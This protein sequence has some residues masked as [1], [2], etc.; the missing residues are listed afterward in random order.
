MNNTIILC[1]ATAAHDTKIDHMNRRCT[2]E[3]SG[4]G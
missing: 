2:V 3:G 4:T 1:A